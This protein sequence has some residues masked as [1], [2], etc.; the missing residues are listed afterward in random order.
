MKA[1]LAIVHFLRRQGFT[2]LIIA[3]CETGLIPR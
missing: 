3:A 2:H 1:A